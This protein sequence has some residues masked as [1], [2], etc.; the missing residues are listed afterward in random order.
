MEKRQIKGMKTDASRMLFNQFFCPL[1]Q[2]FLV[3]G[4][5]YADPSVFL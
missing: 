5:L 3:S 1:Q 4:K 2:R